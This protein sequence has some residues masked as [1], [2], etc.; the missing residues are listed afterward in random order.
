[1][2]QIARSPLTQCHTARQLAEACRLPLPTVGKL[3]RTL[4]KNGMLTSHRG[5]KGGYVLARSPEVIPLTDIISALEGPFALTQCS[6]DIRNLCDLES[7]CPVRDNQRVISQ[8]I[9]G[10]LERVT[11][12]DLT[13]PLLLTAIRDRK[14][15]L[16]PIVSAEIGRTQ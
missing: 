13:R 6:L 11:L 2:C 9:R 14:G 1:M 8:A 7:S 4:L 16:V 10:A 12:S 5:V 3:L 15:H